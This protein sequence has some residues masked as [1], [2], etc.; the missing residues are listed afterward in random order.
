MAL[1]Q[2]FEHDHQAGGNGQGAIDFPDRRLHEH[3]VVEAV[4]QAH[5]LGKLAVDL[6]DLGQAKVLL[7]VP[8]HGRLYSTLYQSPVGLCDT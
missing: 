1:G 3:R 4:D 6:L 8:Q 2:F 5:P 7:E